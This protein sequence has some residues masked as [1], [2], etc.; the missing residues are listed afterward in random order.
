MNK[1]KEAGKHP[2]YSRHYVVFQLIEKG[3]SDRKSGEEA[4][5]DLLNP[6]KVFPPAFILSP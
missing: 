3:L 4:V 1:G 5:Q 2:V 6:C